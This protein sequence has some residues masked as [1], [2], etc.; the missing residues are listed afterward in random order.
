MDCHDDED[1]E[2]DDY[3]RELSPFGRFVYRT[4]QRIRRYELKAKLAE[5]KARVAASKIKAMRKG[6][7][8][9]PRRVPG[10]ALAARQKP[11]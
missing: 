6:R 10:D 5:A 2:D 11:A 7:C 1:D 4:E 9:R 3:E 8:R